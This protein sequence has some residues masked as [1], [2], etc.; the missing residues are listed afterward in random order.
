MTLVG[1]LGE[2][3]AE[4][5]TPPMHRRE[6][7]LLDIDY[8]YRT[9]DIAERGQTVDDLPAILAEVSQQGYDAINVTHPFKQ[10]IIPHLDVL[11]EDAAHL[12]AVNLVVYRNGTATG[13][14][15]D[16][17]GFRF[18]VETGIGDITG[19]R[20][21]LIGSGGAGTA[22]AF[23]LLRLRVEALLLAD[24]DHNTAKRL[25]ARLSATPS[26]ASVEVIDI[27]AVESAIQDVDGLVHAT[28]T[29]MHH[30]PGMAVSIDRLAHAAWVSEIVYLPLE[31]ELVRAARERGHRV[32]DGGRMA[33]GQAVESIRIITGGEPDTARMREHFISL[34]NDP[35]IFR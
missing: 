28:P 19:Q 27:S 25:A 20:V 34:T 10:R 33:V 29:G 8:D 1:L 24:R 18:G 7:R 6:A 13:Y 15:T 2:G 16:W 11:S 14:N 23:A 22:A 4:S 30:R 17:S 12:G 32:L 26:R 35:A 9:I 3:I 31:T 5:L 21:V